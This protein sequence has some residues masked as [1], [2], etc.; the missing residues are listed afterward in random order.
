MQIYNPKAAF[1]WGCDYK[2]PMMHGLLPKNYLHEIK[3]SSTYADDSFAREYLGQWTG[4][5]KDSWF[6]YDKMTKYRKL[7][8]PE[9]NQKI[10]DG[11]DIFYLLSIDVGRLSCETVV[12]VHKVYRNGGNFHSNLV[13]IYTLGLTKETQHFEMQ[14]RDLKLLIKRFAP[15]EVVIDSNGLGVGLMDFMVKPTYCPWG[16]I[17]PAY[18]AFNDDDYGQKI[19]PAIP[20]IYGIKAG[21]ANNGKIHSNCY[22]RV[23]SGRVKFLAR[24]Q[25]IKNKLN[26]TKVGQK[27][28]PIKRQERL[29]PHELTTRLFEEMTNFKI[30]QG[31]GQGNDIKLEKINSNI[32]SDKFSSFEYGLWRIKEKEEEYSKNTKKR[33]R[34]RQLVFVN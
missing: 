6:D 31:V 26:A 24:E 19:Y 29:R 21:S 18:C 7:I 2:V 28:K 13:N 27:M 11:E 10:K 20:I 12:C 33:N 16:E 17:L 4:G 23:F 5:G 34:K 8:N 32:L 25:D 3:L 9:N 22:S 30:K 14:A 15:E 1:V